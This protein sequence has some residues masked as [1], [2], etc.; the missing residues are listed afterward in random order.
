MV[1]NQLDI[2]GRAVPPPKHESPLAVNANTVLP[3]AITAQGLQMVGR[4][5]SQIVE[6][7]SGGNHGK[8]PSKHGLNTTRN[9]ACAVF[10]PKSF[11]LPA[12]ETADHATPFQLLQYTV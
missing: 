6:D 10:P 2:V 3:F 7:R 4:R 12:A 11:E 8:F 5:H 1:I 9:T